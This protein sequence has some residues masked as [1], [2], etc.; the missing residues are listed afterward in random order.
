MRV[1]VLV[2]RY[3]RLVKTCARAYYL[4]GAEG[5]DLIQ[6]GMLGLWRA[7]ITFDPGAGAV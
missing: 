4:A 3:S 7:V 6:E 2:S 1:E 5:D